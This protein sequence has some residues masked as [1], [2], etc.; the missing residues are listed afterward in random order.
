VQR[1]AGGRGRPAVGR[2]RRGLVGVAALPGPPPR[3]ARAGRPG[4]APQVGGDAA[5]AAAVPPPP[6][7]APPLTTGSLGERGRPGRRSPAAPVPLPWTPGGREGS[8]S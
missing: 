6:R 5:G 3:P 8:G 7:L 1:A 4:V 2:A